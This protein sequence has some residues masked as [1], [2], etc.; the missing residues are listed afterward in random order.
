MGVVQLL[1]SDD[2]EIGMLT[3]IACFVEVSLREHLG[4]MKVFKRSAAA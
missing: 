4:Q 1:Q 3:L 2:F